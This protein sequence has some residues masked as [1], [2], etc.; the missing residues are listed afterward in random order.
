MEDSKEFIL[1]AKINNLQFPNKMNN[2]PLVLVIYTH[3]WF[4]QT[5]ESL[6]VDE[7]EK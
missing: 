6:N 4:F 1:Q 7:N 2:L 3:Y 5:P